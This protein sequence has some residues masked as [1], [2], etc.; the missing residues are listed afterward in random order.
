MKKKVLISFLIIFVIWVTNFGL[1]MSDFAK[2]V[3]EDIPKNIEYFKINNVT[4]KLKIDTLDIDNYDLVF[5]HPNE[6]EFKDLIK[7]YGIEIEELN[8]VDSDFG[9]YMTK[10]YD[11]ISKTALTTKI[12]TERILKF[13]TK[14]GVNYFDRMNNNDSEYGVIFNKKECAPRFEFNV[15]TDI[16]IFQILEEYQKNCK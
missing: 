15:I 12:V 16:G 2:G 9:F 7:K 5:F 3:H 11:S 13:R 8:K 10:V 4:I 14:S 1:E 6:T